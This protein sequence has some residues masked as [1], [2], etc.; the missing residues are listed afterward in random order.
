MAFSYF[1]AREIERAAYFLRKKPRDITILDFGSGLGFWSRLAL[2][3]GYT[4]YAF[5]IATNRNS[6]FASSAITFVSDLSHVQNVE[7]DFVHSDQVFEHVQDPVTELSKI[8][9]LM[10]TGAILHLSVPDC[11]G[12]EAQLRS[13]KKGTF[14][15]A[16]APLAHINCFDHDTLVLLGKKC[17]LTLLSPTHMTQGIAHELPQSQFLWKMHESIKYYYRQSFGTNLYFVKST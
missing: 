3:Y 16:A 5:D 1:L 10:K 15:K 17:G 14:M 13:S 2:A 11:G 7:F 6:L 8:T 12:I 9:K 4:V